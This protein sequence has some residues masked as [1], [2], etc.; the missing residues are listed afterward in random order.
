MTPNVDS[1][2]FQISN[3]F[4]YR[5]C[6]INDDLWYKTP[7]LLSHEETLR[8]AIQK[9]LCDM[10][11]GFKP[12]IGKWYYLRA[13]N[14]TASESKKQAIWRFPE[15]SERFV[16]SFCLSS[17]RNEYITKS[18]SYTLQIAIA[19]A[20]S[21]HTRTFAQKS[22]STKLNM[23]RPRPVSQSSLTLA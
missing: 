21:P 23:R 2:I 20:W 1:V 4:P 17:K 14:V 22:Y 3:G 15:Y 5:F 6:F 18:G 16:K 8:T 11:P 12:S 9:E 13:K 19:I 10:H 7:S